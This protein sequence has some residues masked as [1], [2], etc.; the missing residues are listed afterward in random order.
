AAKPDDPATLAAL[1]EVLS[2][3]SATRREAEQD[4]KAAL[5]RDPENLTARVGLAN[6]AAW[7]G[8]PGRALA[9]Y[10]EVLKHNPDETGALKG[11]GSAYNQLGYYSEA[12]GPLE[13]AHQLAPA[14]RVTQTELARA[15]RATAS[16]AEV[17]G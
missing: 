17:S 8:H 5:A 4:F 10:G 15:Q 7:S 13:A 14:D 6:L 1:G 12:R 16:S 3:S 11:Q 9:G 2:W